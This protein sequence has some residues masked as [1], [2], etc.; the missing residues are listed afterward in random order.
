MIQALMSLPLAAQWVPMIVR[1][2]RK[3]TTFEFARFASEKVDARIAQGTTR[4]DFMSRVLENNRDDGTGITRGEINATTV[5]LVIAGS[6]TTATLLSGAVF[7]L[8]RNPAAMAR[9]RKE[10]DDAFASADEI[11]IQRVSHLPYLLAVLEEAL[12]LYPPVPIALGRVTPKD[13]AS[14]CGQWIPGD[15]SVTRWLNQLGIMAD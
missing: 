12:R 11:S 1:H 8:L 10:V 4:P 13:G 14:V 3:G 15:V 7:L 2:I 5:V 9:V 6:E